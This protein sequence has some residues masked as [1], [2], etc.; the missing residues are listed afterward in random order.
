MKTAEI[1]CL[2]F[3]CLGKDEEGYFAK[4]SSGQP[5]V[6]KSKRDMIEV[7]KT[8][9]VFHFDTKASKPGEDDP[10]WSVMGR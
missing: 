3:G 6:I 9:K 2:G 1:L 8:Y 7:G 5:V 10:H 4:V